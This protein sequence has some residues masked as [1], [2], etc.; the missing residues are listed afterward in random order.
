MYN[1]RSQEK[2]NKS[3][4]MRHMHPKRKKNIHIVTVNLDDEAYEVY[5]TVPKMKRSKHIQTLLK[6]SKEEKE[7]EQK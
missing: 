7:T 5:L 6:D 3:K 4:Q 1:Y 2:I